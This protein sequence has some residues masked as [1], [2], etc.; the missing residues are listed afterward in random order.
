M[1]G[2]RRRRWPLLS[3]KSSSVNR[4]WIQYGVMFGSGRGDWRILDIAF[5]YWLAMR[6]KR[7][8]RAAFGHSWPL[9][10]VSWTEQASVCLLLSP[11]GGCLHDGID[12]HIDPAFLHAD[13][14]HFWRRIACALCEGYPVGHIRCFEGSTPG[15]LF[16]AENASA[17]TRAVTNGHRQEAGRFRS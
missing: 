12:G 9:A 13:H 17:A 1:S 6:R 4:Q 14:D 8:A 11:T 2:R 7:I 3:C 10:Y 15:N 16:Y 5:R